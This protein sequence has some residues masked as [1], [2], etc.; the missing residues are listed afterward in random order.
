MTRP[1]AFSSRSYGSGMTVIEASDLVHV[2]TFVGG[3]RARCGAPVGQVLDWLDVANPASHA[4]FDC[5]ACWLDLSGGREPMGGSRPP[6]F[7]RA[8]LATGYT[9]V[10]P[11][12]GFFGDFSNHDFTRGPMDFARMR[13][14]G[15]AG[16]WFKSSD[17]LNFYTDPYFPGAIGQMRATMQVRGAYHVLWGNRSITGQI[18]WWF[19][20]LDRWCPWWRTDPDFVLMSDD[21]PFGYNTA[22][23][24]AQINTAHDY[25]KATT[26]KGSLAYAPP[27]VYGT[28]LDALRWPLV[29]SNYGANPAVH[30]PIGYPGDTSGRWHPQA[31][32]LQ[33]GS[34]LIIGNQSTC[35]T[36]AHR[37]GVA[38]IRSLIGGDV[39]GGNQPTTSELIR[40]LT[41]KSDDRGFLT[42]AN[43]AADPPNQGLGKVLTY[44]FP[45]IE[46]RLTARIDA[47]AAGDAARD[48]VML[49][50]LQALSSGGTSVDTG[51]V[52]AAIR[53]AAAAESA[54]VAA[55]HE[56]LAA[57]TAGR[58][59][60]EQRL[61]AAEQAAADALKP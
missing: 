26:G 39:S 7:D 28:A 19:T 36:N 47:A 57:E 60:A 8:H 44:N 38:G 17:G 41:T 25:I 11:A 31:A 6:A 30:Y 29:S 9:T 58:R 10:G 54:A 45:D 53:D 56:Q 51:V 52:L 61:A 1:D 23:S 2:G 40:I 5:P 32:I 14:D 59:A 27:W 20:I 48:A 34:T 13:D 49:A 43:M 4:S 33:Y 21:E 37:E 15:L 24:I 16:A 18:D 12:T 35:D 42:P 50:A 22:P 55:L 3:H 46:A